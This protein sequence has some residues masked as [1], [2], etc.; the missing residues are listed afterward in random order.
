MKVIIAGAG[1][2]GLALAL[3]CR[4]AG[5]EVSIHER[6]AEPGEVG[7]GLQVSPNG[8][9]VLYA[10]GLKSSIEAVA[11][12]PQ[13]VHLRLAESGSLVLAMPLGRAAEK[14]YGAPWYQLH[15]ADLHALLLDAV[16]RQCGRQ[17]VRADHEL[18]AYEQEPG[19][20]TARFA[21][22]DSERGD[23]LI[24][25]DGIHSRTRQ[26]LF[27]EDTPRYTGHVAWRGVVPAERLRALDL[28][29]VVTSW[30]APHSHAITY[31]LRRGELVNFVGIKEQPAALAESWTGEGDTAELLA[32]LDQ[33]HPTVR[34]I[35]EQ[36]EKPLRWGLYVHD[37]L[38]A[39]ASGRVGLL[40]DAC[41]PML[42]YMAQGA[43]M[44]IEDAWA[45]AACLEG[46][47]DIPAAFERY[48][49]LRMDRTRRVQQIAR[50]NGELF[51]LAGPLK[52][53]AVFGGMALGARLLPGIVSRR[54]DWIVG[55]DITSEQHL[56]EEGGL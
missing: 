38:A 46:A 32:D 51:H 18:V 21:G 3:A 25:A 48:Q 22:G 29:P 27:G 7:A 31:F 12:K 9:K 16:R 5:F 15:R 36:I 35:A 10:L 39:W 6:V 23:V 13:A 52:R 45:L 54:H 53:M 19:S 1:I 4:K 14:R 24:G 33:W 2:G 44:A 26:C 20:V 28:A 47:A 11:F 49:A 50:A 41:H 56:T 8:A 55:Y 34:Q 43:V 30:M 42:P 37:P 17:A 40:G